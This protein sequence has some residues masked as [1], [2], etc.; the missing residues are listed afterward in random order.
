MAT[1]SVDQ[2]ALVIDN[3]TGTIKAG[4]AGDDAP[5]SVFKTIVGKPK[6][7]GIMVGLDQKDIYVGD[8]AKEKKG[9]LKLECPIERGLIKDWDDMEKVWNHT[10]YQ[11]MKTTPEEQAILLTEP[12]LNPKDN[13]ERTTQIMFEYFHVPCL[14]IGIQ[15]VLALYASG[16]TTGLVVDCGEGVTHT[17]PIYEGFA[18]PHAIPRIPLAGCDLTEYFQQ[19]LK[20][21]GYSFTTPDD[22]E[23]VTYLKEREKLC[24][25]ALDYEKTKAEAT[26]SKAH[27]RK[28]ELPD[29]HSIVIGLERFQVPEVLFDPA[30]A[31]IQVDGIHKH[32]DESIKKCDQDIRKD[33]YKNIILAGGCTM[34]N[35]TKE[36]LKK[37]VKKLAQPMT[38]VETQ[39]PPERRFSAW[40]GGSI[41][42][43]LS[44]F[45]AMYITRNEYNEAGVEIVHRKCF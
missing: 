18:V 32:A 21:L 22:M 37:E 44:T 28:E 25:V 19:L 38:E 15:A 9:V 16:R 6:M 2:T 41:V 14:Y 33:L 10:I 43:S 1:P 3:G 23:M 24:E 30:L 31:G 5:R 4:I 45:P 26:D 13:R 20:K 11:E 39:A 40:I 27:E 12:P 35:G 42:A 7:P 36:R 8:E 34:F 29:G 17:V